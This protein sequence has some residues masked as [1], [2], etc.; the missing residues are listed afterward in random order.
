MAKIFI[1]TSGEYSDY[2]IDAAFSTREKAEEYVDIY[3]PDYMIKE[4]EVDAPVCDKDGMAISEQ[5]HPVREMNR[6]A[7]NAFRSIATHYDLYL[8]TSMIKL[9]EIWQAN[10]QR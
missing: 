5:R 9:G 6:L 7:I 8:C 2:H 10:E 3:G 4:Y 1:V